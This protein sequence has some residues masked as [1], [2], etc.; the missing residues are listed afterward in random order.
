[1]EN[2]VTLGG[3]GGQITSGRKFK[4]SLANMSYSIAQAIEWY[5]LTSLQTPP[6]RLKQFLCLS[7]P[8]EKGFHHVGQAG[9]KL[10]TSGD[11][12]ASVSQSAGI[13]GMSH[14]AQL[15]TLKKGVG[16]RSLALLHRLECRGVI[17]AQCNLRLPGSS[18]S[19]ASASRVDGITGTCHHAQLISAFL[20]EMKFH[21]I[22][23]AGLELLTSGDPPTTA[24]QSAGITGV[25][26]HA[27][28]GRTLRGKQT[29]RA[30]ELKIG[31]GNM[32]F[33][34]P[35]QMDPLRSGVGRSQ[36]REMEISLANMKNSPGG[37]AHWLTPVILALWE[38]K[39]GESLEPRSSR[40][41]S[42]TYNR[43]LELISKY[44]NYDISWL[45]AVESVCYPS[46]LGDQGWQITSDGVLQCRSGWSA[47]AR[48]RLA[49][50]STFRVQAVLCLS[51]LKSER[52]GW[53]QWLTPVIAALWEANVGGS[54]GQEIKT[55]LTNMGL[56]LSLRLEG[57]GLIS[58]HCH[59]RF[60]G[61]SDSPASDSQL[62]RRLKQEN[63]LNPGGR[64][65]SEPRSCHCTPAWATEQDS[66][67]KKKKKKLDVLGHVTQEE[68]EQLRRWME[69]PATRSIA[70]PD[71]KSHSV[72]RLECSGMM[73]AHCNLCLPGSSN[74]PA[75]ASQTESPSIARLE[76][77]G[78]ILA[79]CNF[80]FLVSSNSPASASRVA[81]T[82]GTHH[83]ARLIFC[84]LL[85]RWESH[86]VTQAAVQWCDLGSLHLHLPGSSNSPAPASQVA[87][88]T[89]VLIR[90]GECPGHVRWLM[91][92]IP[93]L[94]EAKGGR[95]SEVRSSR[96]AWLIWQNPV[97]TKTTK[98]SWVRWRTPAV[99]E[100]DTAT[101]TSSKHRLEW[102]GSHQQ[103]AQPYTGKKTMTQM[104]TRIFFEME[105]RSLPRLECN[106]TISAH[107]NLHL[108]GSSNSP[109]SASRV[110]GTRG[111]CH[112]AQ[113][114][115]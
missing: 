6:L 25:S 110:A 88:T 23:Q 14:Q 51:L 4:T 22:G 37:R 57:S 53:A 103:E 31:L 92:V 45:D 39:A 66:V 46:T 52:T 93:A 100:M 90:I 55:I 78:A 10:L 12:P 3:Q 101:P 79:H 60:P 73:S 77:S 42:A 13:T 95:L 69:K 26:H 47:L 21:H 70:S 29:S 111:M 41:T 74:S 87:E 48:S 54:R 9:L 16:V 107:R 89:A 18:D 34:K 11:L 24:S 113:L 61:S 38:A 2:D 98:I 27:R 82:T 5:D 43:V 65:C 76:C 63:H 15:K 75:S 96:P 19:S 97:S 104:V 85:Q 36:G 106:G 102:W 72:T 67:S 105:F 114:T 84:T 108:L 58:A 112:H 71:T 99:L 28:P 86:S 80:H 115:F 94:W 40:L 109:A 20:V 1:M 81:G 62:L 83:H 64:G 68:T 59:F 30:Q 44:I 33:G 35:R 7:L 49:I 17:S 50:T 8:I 32:H 91:P 56:A